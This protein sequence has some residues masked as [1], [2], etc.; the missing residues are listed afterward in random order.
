MCLA[1]VWLHVTTARDITMDMWDW[2]AGNWQGITD[3]EERARAH[4]QSHLLQGMTARVVKVNSQYGQSHLLG[5]GW[6]ATLNEQGEIDWHFF[7]DMWAS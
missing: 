6:T 3:S 2:K 4:A 5:S 7:R 1:A